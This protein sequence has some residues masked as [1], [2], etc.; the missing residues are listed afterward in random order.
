[1][2]APASPMTFPQG[3]P[4][5]SPLDIRMQPPAHVIPFTAVFGSL[6]AQQQAML[7]QME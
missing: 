5:L 4:M 6:S 3:Q 2:P 1:M 7:I